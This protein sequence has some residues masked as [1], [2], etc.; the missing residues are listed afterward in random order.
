[1]SEDN[2]KKEEGKFECEDEKFDLSQYEE[3]NYEDLFSE[4]KCTHKNTEL[5]NDV[6]ICTDCGTELTIDLSMEPEWRY[7]GEH[8]NK[9]TSDPSRCHLRKIDEK[10]IYKE[11]E[12]LQLPKEVM[13]CANELYDDVVRGDI[14]RS[15]S[16]MS[17]IYASVYFAC[18]KFNIPT[19]KT[20]ELNKKFKLKK[21]EITKGIRSFQMKCSSR[22]NAS[23][24]TCHERIIPQI[25]R[26]FD[27]GQTDI[28]NVVKLY[29]KIKNKSSVLT[30][31]S[32]CSVSSGLVFYY[33]G[34][35]G[36]KISS[37]EFSSKV[38]FSE[39]TISRIAKE[40]AKI[41]KG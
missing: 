9:N 16:R 29:N 28:E 5:Q 26:L 18:Q 27:M 37:K 15:K 7:Y 8:D 33:L 17:L 2:M 41:V 32:P 20:N 14:K 10:N 31:P 25:M 40:V 12:S 4:E 39:L 21:K 36:K 38:N 11:I 35:I 34:S 6:R 1:M 3:E 22:K 23:P 30:R 24:Q 19:D 13:T